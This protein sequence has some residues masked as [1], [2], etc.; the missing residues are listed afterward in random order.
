MDKWWPAVSIATITFLLFPHHAQ[1]KT[2][3]LNKSLSPCTATHD[4]V[5]GALGPPKVFGVEPPCDT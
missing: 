5:R 1:R 4:D 3:L 2:K